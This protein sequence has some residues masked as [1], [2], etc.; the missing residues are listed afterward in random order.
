MSGSTC[1]ELECL[2]FWRN[3]GLFLQENPTGI[4]NNRCGG[5]CKA[6]GLRRCRN[7]GHNHLHVLLLTVN[8]NFL[9]YTE[10]LHILFIIVLYFC[11]LTYLNS[12]LCR[13]ITYK[14]KQEKLLPSDELLSALEYIRHM[15]GV[16]PSLYFFINYLILVY[17]PTYCSICDNYNIRF[18]RIQKQTS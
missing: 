6:N 4:C 5:G 13:L 15:R 12:P 1:D 7:S 9:H 17:S 18:R 3:I 2:Q 11:F 10:M 14:F 16:F 8:S